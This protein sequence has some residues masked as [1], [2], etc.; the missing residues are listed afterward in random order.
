MHTPIPEVA[1]AA[2]TGDFATNHKRPISAAPH[3]HAKEC[4]APRQGTCGVRV[5]SERPS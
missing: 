1:H 2:C 3:A 5:A 4:R